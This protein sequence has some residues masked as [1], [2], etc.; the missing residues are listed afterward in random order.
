MGEPASGAANTALKTE[1]LSKTSE[2]A[3][4]G[5]SAAQLSREENKRIQ[6]ERRKAEREVQR[7]EAEIEAAEAEK[8]ALEA[9]LSN[10]DVYSNGAKAKQVQTEIDAVSK[11]L[12]GLNSDWET[13]MEK[14]G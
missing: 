2:A 4:S 10:P 9:K 6:A 14:L 8:S 13:A 3:N 5:K 11:K 1:Q 12:D 7:I